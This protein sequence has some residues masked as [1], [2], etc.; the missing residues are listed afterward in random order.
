[1]TR[2]PEIHRYVIALG[3]SHSS[4]FESPH[5]AR[6][7]IRNL[8]DHYRPRWVAYHLVS[9][10]DLLSHPD[11]IMTYCAQESKRQEDSR[12]GVDMVKRPGTE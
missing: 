7:F 6:E 12:G 5:R 8:P 4:P 2:C 9:I 11:E 3:Q 10:E 1:M